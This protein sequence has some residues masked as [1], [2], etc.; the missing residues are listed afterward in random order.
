MNVLEAEAG[1]RSK[2]R[3]ACCAATKALVVL[4]LKSREK[5]PKASERGFLASLGVTAAASHGRV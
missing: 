3:T 2:A 1:S 5:S 4:M